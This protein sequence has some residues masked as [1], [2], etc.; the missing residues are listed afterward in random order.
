MGDKPV[1]GS[2]SRLRLVLTVARWDVRGSF[3]VQLLLGAGIWTGLLDVLVPVHI[4]IGLLFV[5]GLLTV[6]VLAVVAGGNLIQ[7]GVLVLWAG[8]IVVLGLT[9]A[10]L[11][12]GGLHWIIQVVHL[13]FGVAGIGQAEA[14][15]GAAER[16]PKLPGQ[17]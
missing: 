5:L 10:A 3:I 7:V 15:A 11:L 16:S 6:A 9:Q 17:S 14:L 12:P 8:L 1:I 13:A 4:A 2:G